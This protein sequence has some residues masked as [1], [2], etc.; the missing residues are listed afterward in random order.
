MINAN[1]NL[2]FAHIC[3]STDSDVNNLVECWSCT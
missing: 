3:Y 1:P 2:F